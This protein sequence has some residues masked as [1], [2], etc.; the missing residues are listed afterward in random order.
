MYY[1]PLVI[2]AMNVGQSKRVAVGFLWMFGYCQGCDCAQG[3]EQ[4][5]GK[6]DESPQR[7]VLELS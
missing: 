5:G 2:Q 6:S 1:S 4:L 7:R 3:F